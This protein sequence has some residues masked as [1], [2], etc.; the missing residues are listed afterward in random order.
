MDSILLLIAQILGVVIITIDVIGMTKLTTGKV[1]LFNGISNGLAVIQYLVLGAWTGALCC[2][3]AVLRNIVFSRHKNK[4]PLYILIIYIVIAVAL[5]IT[6]IHSWI[7]I[8]PIINIVIYAIALWTKN[9]MNIKVVG[10]ATCVD[11]VVYDY[12]K[13]AYVTVIKE[14]LDGVIAIR[15]IYLLIKENKK[16]RTK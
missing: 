14:V 12:S 5:N 16:K 8:I 7:D 9:I 3:I 11:G 6:F 2:L 4:V 13:Q 15:C 10:L 1:Y